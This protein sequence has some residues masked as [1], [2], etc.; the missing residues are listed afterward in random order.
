MTNQVTETEMALGIERGYFVLGG[1]DL[2]SRQIVYDYRTSYIKER[3]K[4]SETSLICGLRKPS[5]NCA[6]YWLE[7]KNG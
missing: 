3:I 7:E 6:C 2:Q 5:R 4:C 1:I